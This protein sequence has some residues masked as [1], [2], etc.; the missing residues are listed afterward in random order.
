MTSRIKRT[1]EVFDRGKDLKLSNDFYRTYIIEL[2]NFLLKYDRYDSDSSL[3]PES[4]Y[5]K[6]STALIISKDEGVTSCIEEVT[7]FARSKGLEVKPVKGEG[8]FFQK[9]EV[10][11][12]IAG[13]ARKILSTERVILNILQRTCAISTATRRLVEKIADL[14][15]Q[16]AAT[17]KTLLGLIEKK[18]VSSAGGLTHR[19][20]LEEAAMIKDNHLKLLGDSLGEAIETILHKKPKLS[21]LE[22][23][24]KNKEEFRRVIELTDRVRPEIPIVIM[25]DHFKPEDISNIVDDLKRSPDLYELVFLEASGNIT[26]KNIIEYAQ[27][28]VDVVSVGCIT[29]SVKAK[30]FTLLIN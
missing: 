27:S 10:L 7:F 14:G 8:D 11:L 5:A 16:I 15:C 25:F 17:R 1:R 9:G 22:I 6:T 30:D 24:V 13:E 29:H 28:G 2:F 23:E 18:A 26:E 4:I 19:L 12:E 20:N 21:F 3:L